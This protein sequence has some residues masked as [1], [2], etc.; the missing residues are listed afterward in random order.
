M[1]SII[2]LSA[3]K[4]LA[5]YYLA[6]EATVPG[7]GWAY[8]KLTATTSLSFAKQIV[9]TFAEY[10]RRG[11][12]TMALI[13]VAKFR[14]FV[15]K[16]EELAARLAAALTADASLLPILSRARDESV[17]F[18]GGTS[19][20]VCMSVSWC[21]FGVQSSSIR[22]LILLLLCTYV[23]Y[24]LIRANIITFITGNSVF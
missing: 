2:T 6:S 1:S 11:P 19:V 9:E 5:R 17:S 10:N 23:Q 16:F 12:K 21:C 14:T 7:H 13:D 8:H 20:R 4:D 22:P 18:N 3:F 15:V 24:L